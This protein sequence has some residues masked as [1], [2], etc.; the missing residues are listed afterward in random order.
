MRSPL[1]SRSACLRR[2]S[3]AARRQRRLTFP[4]AFS[5]GTRS[6]S[7]AAVRVVL[8]I[9]SLLASLLIRPSTTSRADGAPPPPSACTPAALVFFA[10]LS[11]LELL[12]G[13]LSANIF[14][15]A[16]TSLLRPATNREVPPHQLQPQRVCCKTLGG[17]HLMGVGV[18]PRWRCSVERVLFFLFWLRVLRMPVMNCTVLIRPG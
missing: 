6:G 14:S 1:L 2:R 7:P 15:V 18:A 17:R 4:N 5:L 11:S 8:I 10:C 16:D 12:L 9:A 3:S 13:T